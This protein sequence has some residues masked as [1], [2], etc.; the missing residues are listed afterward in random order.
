M[1]FNILHL[2]LRHP[3][4]D[5]N[6]NPLASEFLKRLRG[7]EAEKHILEKVYLAWQGRGLPLDKVSLLARRDEIISEYIDNQRRRQKVWRSS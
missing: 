1:D 6:P 3:L 7:T 4:V 2:L 5:I